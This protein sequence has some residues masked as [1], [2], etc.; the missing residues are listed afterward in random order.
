VRNVEEREGG[1]PFTQGAQ[2]G[3]VENRF[4]TN[5]TEGRLMKR[6]G[7]KAN[8]RAGGLCPAPTLP[9]FPQTRK[10]GRIFYNGGRMTPEKPLPEGEG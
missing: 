2:I 6:A 10:K 4:E 8:V 7:R 3:V 9:S 1:F 5:R